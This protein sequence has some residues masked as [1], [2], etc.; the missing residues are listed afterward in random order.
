MQKTRQHSTRQF[1]AL[2]ILLCINILLLQGCASSSSGSTKPPPLSISTTSLPSGQVGAAYSTTLVETGGTPPFTWT[3][4]SG[5]LPA[6][7]MLNASTGAITGTPT[8]SASN[9]AL[10]F[11]VKDSGSPVQSKS[12]N[13]TLTIAP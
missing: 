10:T 5:T 12:V 3:T 9:L 7:L 4:T 13:L 6:G 11:Q 2:A 8:A 1:S